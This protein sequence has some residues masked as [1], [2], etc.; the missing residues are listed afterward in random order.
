MIGFILEDIACC[1]VL[2]LMFYGLIKVLEW[3]GK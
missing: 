1:M 3:C 2:G